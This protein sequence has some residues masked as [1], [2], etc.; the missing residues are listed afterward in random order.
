V[1][2]NGL[3]LPVPDALGVQPGDSFGVFAQPNGHIVFR[4]SAK[5]PA[6][7]DSTVADYDL[8]A[9]LSQITPDTLHPETDFGPPVG[10]EAW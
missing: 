1:S 2:G 9:L 3:V 10:K 6:P 5:R 7:A 8:G 4:P